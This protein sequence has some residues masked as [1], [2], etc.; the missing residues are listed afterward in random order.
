M[1]VFQLIDPQIFM[2]LRV[3]LKPLVP[4][5]PC[6]ASV[7]MSL[8]DKVTLSGAGY[9]LCRRISGHFC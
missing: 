8:M 5:F 1:R 3:T 7:G 9:P 4:T 6:F 2:S